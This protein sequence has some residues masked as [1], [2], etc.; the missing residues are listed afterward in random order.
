M[1]MISL[2]QIGH[3]GFVVFFSIRVCSI[4]SEIKVLEL[5]AVWLMSK[6]LVDVVVLANDTHLDGLFLSKSALYDLNTVTKYRT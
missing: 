5:E 1:S 3:R 2:R 4:V 6:S